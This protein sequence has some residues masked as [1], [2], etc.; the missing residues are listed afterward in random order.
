MKFYKISI[1]HK[2]DR[3]I[4]SDIINKNINSITY[5]TIKKG[6]I[7]EEVLKHTQSINILLGKK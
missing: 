7:R 6:K 4:I 2:D 5:V 1:N 3:G